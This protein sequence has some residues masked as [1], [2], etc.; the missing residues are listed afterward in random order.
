MI[1]ERISILF[2]NEK[3]LFNR[4]VQFADGSKIQAGNTNGLRI[5]T[6]ATQ[7]IAFYGETPVLQ[8]SAITAPTDAGALYSQSQ[9]QSVVDKVNALIL[10]VKNFGIIA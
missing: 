7:K 5:G 9:A 1:T 6:E 8:A 2:K 10:A 4:P 3:Y